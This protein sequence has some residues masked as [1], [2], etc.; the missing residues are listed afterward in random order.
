[1][2]SISIGFW[3]AITRNGRGRGRVSPATVTARSCMASSSADWVLGVARLTSSAST[4]LAKIGPGR[5]RKL[6]RPASSSSSTWVP[7]M[8]AGMRSGV[9]WTRLKGRST[10][11]D[12]VLRSMVLPSPGT[13]S[14]RTWPSHSMHTRTSR[15]SSAW[16]TITRPICSS[17]ARARSPYSSGLIDWGRDRH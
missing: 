16:P 6:R 5:K 1:M 4:R 14:S 12:S 17:M 13:P 9:N 2:P 11:D 8:S 15:T 3:V 7:R 10:A